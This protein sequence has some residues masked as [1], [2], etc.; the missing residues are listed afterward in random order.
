LLGGVGGLISG[1]G[2][3]G[4]SLKQFKADFQRAGN[5]ARDGAIAEEMGLAGGKDALRTRRRVFKEI[6]SAQA[7]VDDDGSVSSRK[8]LANRV[9]EIAKRNGDFAT[10]DKAM[11][12]MVELDREG[13]ELKKLGLE[14]EA[15]EHDQGR[16]QELGVRAWHIDATERQ[17]GRAVRI[18]EGEDAGR[19]KLYEP[20]NPDK[21]RIVDGGELNIPSG[22]LG[23]SAPRRAK[24]ETM[25]GIVAANGA[26]GPRIT[27]FRNIPRA[28]Q[29]QSRIIDQILGNFFT[30]SEQGF[31][32]AIALDASGKTAIAADKTISF[33]DTVSTMFGFTGTKEERKV[34]YGGKETTTAKQR[35]QFIEAGK[36]TKID[37]FAKEMGYSDRNAMLPRELQGAPAQAAELYWANIMELAY[38][39]ARIQE[40]SNRGL[41]D[42]DIIAALKRIGA[43]TANPRSFAIRQREVIMNTLIPN[44][45]NLG[46]QMSTFRNDRFTPQEVADEIFGKDYV[47]T[48]RAGLEETVAKLDIFIGDAKRNADGSLPRQ[49]STAPAGAAEPASDKSIA[50]QLAEA[51]AERAL[52]GD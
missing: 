20:G 5:D 17:A 26:G 27:E 33:V 36:A 1:K 35:E 37:A 7:S 14:N 50:D 23:G 12:Q 24:H 51:R 46:S 32:P 47:A 39:D 13:L 4:R 34:T 22:Q 10:L 43:D 38:L 30:L 48:V 31:D 19:Y 11:A 29:Q 28:M 18:N 49:A 3:D 15:T 25:Q 44:L 6:Q 41:S 45:E 42:N 40:P 8:A 16:K 21:F 52:L 9:A 2:D